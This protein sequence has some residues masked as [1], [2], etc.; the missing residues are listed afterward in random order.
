MA[1]K[2]MPQL[3]IGKYI[4][5]FPII[6]GG[7]GIMSSGPN[8]AGA[9]ASAGGIGT[10]ASVGLACYSSEYTGKNFAEESIKMI[11]KCVEEAR[12]LANG[13][14]LAMNCMCALSNYEDIIRASCDAGIDIIVS[15]AGLPLKLPELTA[16][17]PTTA[18][19]PIVSSTK[20]AKLILERWEKKYQK[21]PDA[22]V[23]ET[24]NSAGGHLG[25][26]DYE[27]AEDHILSL[28]IVIP[29]LITFL[30]ERGL[31]IPIISAGGIWDSEDM[32]SSFDMG[33]TG[34][35]LGTRFLA[36]EEGDA[37]DRFKQA[38]L[39]ATNEDV[40]LIHSPCGLPGRAIRNPFIDRYLKGTL[41]KMTCKIGCLTHCVCKMKHETFC[42]ADALMEA[43]KGDWEN[44]L[45]FCGTNVSKVK[46][47]EKVK[48]I[49]NELMDGCS[50]EYTLLSHT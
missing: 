26:K 16:N 42:I 9:V 27:T 8:L 48:D 39:D 30:K 4:P 12:K 14:I 23:V 13:G 10:I 1:K 41:E 24:P 3:K 33:A 47:I 2:S 5:K 22:F 43:Y 40:V 46:S 45:F 31:N 37:S 35:Q 50:K 11:Y 44:G 18:L 20:A 38:Y 28:E 7:M 34:V 21:L 17:S 36:T 6:Q 19:V 29:E 49:I 32:I 25:A 15:G